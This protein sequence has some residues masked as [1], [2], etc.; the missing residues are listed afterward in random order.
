[1]RQPPHLPRDF[2]EEVEA[3][4]SETAAQISGDHRRFAALEELVGVCRQLRRDLGRPVN[5]FDVMRTAQGDAER[6]R[7]HELICTL[8]EPDSRG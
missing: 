4:L 3:A 1:M 8:R 7:R 2:L 6:Q 5:V